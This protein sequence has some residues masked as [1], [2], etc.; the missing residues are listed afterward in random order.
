MKYITN[1]IR[2]ISTFSLLFLNVLPTSAQTWQS[3][4]QTYSN[5]SSGD[6]KV[7]ASPVS[8]TVIMA[9]EKNA[10]PSGSHIS[11]DGGNTWQQIFADKPMQAAL[12]APNGNIYLAS[13]KRYLSTPTYNTD[14]LFS[15]SN[16][17]NWTN[18]GAFGGSGFHPEGSF[19]VTEN[20]TLLLPRVDGLQGLYFNKSTDNGQNWVN[21]GYT[22]SGGSGSN[23]IIWSV[24]ASP[25]CDTIILGTY[26]SGVRYSHDGGAT[27]Q[28]STGGSWGAATVGGAVITQHG[29]SYVATAGSVSKSTDGG[30]TFTGLTYIPS[31]TMTIKEFLYHKPSGKFFIHAVQGIFESSDCIT[32]TNITGNLTDAHLIIDIAVSQDYIFVTKSNED[33]LYRYQITGTTGVQEPADDKEIW[34]YP[35][36]SSDYVN[37]GN[38]PIGSTATITDLTGKTVYSSTIAQINEIVN[39][40]DFANGI[41]FVQGVK[42]GE[43]ISRKF[44][45]NK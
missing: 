26:N 36:P 18:L 35:N 10:T 24:A 3:L 17:I 15:S 23:S 25:A 6:K 7:F 1:K 38:L 37:I 9:Y 13:V 39:T 12:F 32:W 40:I 19:C 45:V 5:F 4:S 31:V 14:S 41:Y 2:L 27:W 42:N 21:T 43:V 29:N 8:N 11:M 33:N 16:G 30:V 28:T 20:N 22:P 44:I 34:L